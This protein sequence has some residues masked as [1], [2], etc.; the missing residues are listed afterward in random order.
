MPVDRC[1]TGV[2]SVDALLG[3][4]LESDC[5]TELYG[6][7]GSGKTLLCLEVAVR[8]ALADRWVFYIDTEGVSVDRLEAIAGGRV[9]QVLKRLLLATPKN[10][11][12]QTKAVGTAAALAREARRPVGLIVL[13]SATFYYRL[14]LSG[15]DEDEGRLALVEE[16]AELMATAL[17]A[18][19]PVLFTNQVWTRQTDG[20][21]EPLGGTFVNHAAKTILRLDRLTG[22][23]RR[24][25]LVKHRSLGEAS[26]EFRITNHG[27][28][29]PLE[30]A[31]SS[32]SSKGGSS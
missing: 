24:A 5:L 16:L 29:G 12:E 6:E 19:V 14:S 15:P 7:G 2:P 20:S 8:L 11:E 21:L 18:Q 4:G 30:R 31:P 23:R 1:P 13:D 9:D 32:S 27:L 26:A 28:S 22:A 10:L 3:G 25:V 17:G